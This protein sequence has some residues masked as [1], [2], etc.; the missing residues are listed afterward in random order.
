MGKKSNSN[1][2]EQL[3]FAVHNCVSSAEPKQTPPFAAPVQLRVP[4][5]NL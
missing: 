2:P 1:S 5:K 4:I 3:T